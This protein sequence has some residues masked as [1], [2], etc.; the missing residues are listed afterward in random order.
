[1]LSKSSLILLFSLVLFSS[2][3]EKIDLDLNTDSGHVVIDA[4]L[5]DASSLQRIR[6]SQSVAFDAKVGSNAVKNATVT[7]KDN[8]NQTY[9]FQHEKDGFYI[10]RNF[11]P[12]VGRKY[13]LRVGVQKQQ[14]ESSSSMPPYVNV[15]ATRIIEKEIAGK[16]YFFIAL[17]F[18]DPDKSA[19]YYMYTLSING[20]EFRFASTESDQFNDGLQVTHY[21]SDLERSLSPGDKISI[22]RY[23]VDVATYN[24]WNGYQSTNLSTSAPGNPKS[25]ISNNALGYFSVA[26]VKEYQLAIP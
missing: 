7:V 9:L 12:V 22:R 13:T 10:N 11:K 1:M 26:P 16:T 8:L 3:E 25:N 19:N 14:F 5:S 21:I 6:I 18:K 17:S 23:C 2:C 4:Q 15:D 24:Y 20:K